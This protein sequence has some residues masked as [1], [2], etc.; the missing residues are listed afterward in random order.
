M[1]AGKRGTSHSGLGELYWDRLDNAAKL[2]PAV[3]DTRGTN[4]FRVSAVLL[5]EIDP[6]L[7]QSALERALKILPAFAVKLHHGLF[8]YYLDVN[9]ETPRVREEYLYPCSPIWRTQERGFLFRVTY[10][11]RRVNFEVFHALTDGMGALQFLIL[12]LLCYFNLSYP[13]EPSSE[14]IRGWC[15][16][17]A[18]DYDEDSFSKHMPSG[19]DKSKSIPEPDAYHI[20]GYKYDDTR[21]NVLCLLLPV[22]RMLELA[23][24]NSST[25]SEYLASLLIYSIYESSYRRSRLK[26]PIA[27]SLPVNL[28]QMF[29]STT[30]RNFFGH[31]NIS[32]TPTENMRFEDILAL[33]K[34]R[35]KA[36]LNRENFERQIAQNVAI[37]RITAVKLVPIWL[38]DFI[39]RRFFSKA[40]KKYTITFSN[41]GAVKLPDAIS[42]RVRR[43]EMLL[44]A[45]RTH[46]KKVSVCSYKNE[47]AL[48][49]S[50]TIDDNQL[51]RCFVKFLVD[52]GVDISISSNETPEP[53]KP[54]KQKPRSEK[55]ERRKSKTD[56]EQKP[57][58]DVE[59]KP[60][61]DA[62]QKPI[63]DAEQKPISDAEQKPISDA[64]Q[65]PVPDG[66]QKSCPDREIV[67]PPSD[68]RGKGEA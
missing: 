34:E 55:R 60:I 57:V 43:F 12:L 40:E 29:S 18:R 31:I 48:S 11:H 41:L 36:S 28:R 35:F 21:L 47:L 54:P 6:E 68:G 63:S 65:K 50:S 24:E 9:R 3:S 66:E 49:F 61:S 22:D 53:H 4:V 52:R 1:A 44:G 15:E 56:N 2:V 37:E 51:E 45:S 59:Q 13:G 16:E 7:L 5:D 38:K 10:Y 64:E 62:E 30:M 39:M 26:K 42:S 8:W 19:I 27:V 33:V 46:P 67:N 23:H 32:V 25:L 17:I 58:P 20:Q 14:Y